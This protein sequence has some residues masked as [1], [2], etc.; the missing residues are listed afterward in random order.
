M[1]QVKDMINIWS[2]L[3]SAITMTLPIT[4][5]KNF[6]SCWERFTA[7]LRNNEMLSLLHKSE[8]PTN[9]NIQTIELNAFFLVNKTTS[10]KCILIPYMHGIYHQ[11]NMTVYT[12]TFLRDLR[13]KIERKN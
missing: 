2:G 6:S 9:S 5:K 7:T 3:L 13:K 10:R 11:Q 1:I 4:F 12:L 8:I